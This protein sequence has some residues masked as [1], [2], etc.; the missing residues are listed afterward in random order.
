MK[1]STI[2]LGE[3]FVDFIKLVNLSFE[4]SKFKLLCGGLFIKADSSQHKD[5][6][7]TK[8]AETSQKA[9]FS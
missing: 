9:T 6:D 2:L 3:R 4:N 7:N 1:V 5:F 8:E